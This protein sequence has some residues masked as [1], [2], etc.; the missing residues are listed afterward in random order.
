MVARAPCREAHRSPASRGVQARRR[1]RSA[2]ASSAGLDQRDDDLVHDLG[3]VVPR[4]SGSRCR[5]NRCV[6]TAGM[7]SATSA[8]AA[9][10]RT[11]PRATP[12]RA[13]QHRRRG[14]APGTARR[15]ARASSGR[16]RPRTS[17]RASRRRPGWPGSAAMARAIAVQ[18]LGGGHRRPSIGTTPHCRRRGQPGDRARPAPAPAWSASAGRCSP[19]RSAPGRRRSRR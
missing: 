18:R 16:R 5:I 4:S 9:S 13:A 19:C 7:T 12:R 6:S 11:S 10:G 15:S 1:R 14:A 8:A 3:Q 17:S 2:R